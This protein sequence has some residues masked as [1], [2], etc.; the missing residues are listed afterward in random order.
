MKDSTTRT[1]RTA[2]Q[3][4]IA[5]AAVAPVMLSA[6][7]IEKSAGFGA[8]ILAAAAAVTRL[9]QVPAVNDFLNK[10]FGVPK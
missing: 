7:G 2:V 4:L 6:V 1:I 3:A 10:Y 5:V 8:M 9:H